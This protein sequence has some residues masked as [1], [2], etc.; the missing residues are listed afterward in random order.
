MLPCIDAK[1]AIYSPYSGLYPNTTSLHEANFKSF[2]LCNNWL[3]HALC[4]LS[5]ET[6]NSFTPCESFMCT[7]HVG[8]ALFKQI[9][10]GICACI[11]YGALALHG[12]QHHMQCR[13]S[14][15]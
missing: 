13:W 12:S 4:L 14:K 1:H 10:A 15:H 3:Q 2:N 6:Y 11:T 9:A 8:H 7:V 5:L